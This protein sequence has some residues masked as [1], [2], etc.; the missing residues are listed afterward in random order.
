MNKYGYDKNDTYT[1]PPPADYAPFLPSMAVQE[2]SRANMT[3]G[4]IIL[5][6]LAAIC[7]A[8]GAGPGT[9]KKWIKEEEFPV[10]KCSDGIYRASPESI[11]EWFSRTTR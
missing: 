6:G 9:I 5:V 2:S 3:N 7:R 4:Q 8:V 10:R 1:A 11:K